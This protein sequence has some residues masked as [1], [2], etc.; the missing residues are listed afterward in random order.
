ML[1]TLIRKELKAIILSPKFTATFAV[2]SVLM[3]ISVY[4][5]I[6]EY[7]AT[8]AQ[9]ASAQQLVDQ[10]MQELTSWADVRDKA[11]RPPDPLQVFVAGLNYDIGRLSNINTHQ[12]VKLQNSI[13]SDDPI[14]A[15]F[16]FIDFAFIVQVVLSLFAILFTYDAVSGEREQGTL[17]LVFSNAIPRAR[18][19][20]AKFAGAWIGLAV[21]ISV[22]ILLGILLV[23]L[24]KVPFTATHWVRLLSLIGVSLLFFTFFIALGV[25]ISTITRRSNVS[26]LIG[27]VVW[28]TF[29]LII[30]RAGVLAAGQLVSV[31][32]VAEIESQRDRYA[33]GLW[34]EHEQKIQEKWKARTN[35]GT[36]ENSEQDE[37]EMWNWLQEDDAL[38]RESQQ[39]I[40]DFSTRLNED[41]R[42]RKAVQTRLAFTLSRI[43]PASAYQLA[44]M[45]IA[46]TDLAMK[47]RYEDVMNEYRARFKDYVEQ[48]QAEDPMGGKMMIS[49][50]SEDGISFNSP[51]EAATID[52]SG[53]PRFVAPETTLAGAVAPAILDFG[54]LALYTLAV[55]AGAFA[56]FLRYDVR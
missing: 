35:T 32:S 16:R 46:G 18:Y 17:R 45:S 3:L 8:A 20:L 7:R 21:P 31:P 14:Y 2:C 22:P 6:R 51:R 29:V 54:L 52:V 34:Q 11:L 40:D 5:G 26:F 56:L 24:Y 55:F 33:Q 41:L 4:I 50:S 30:P 36:S 42:R 15:V 43:S 23:T 38:R 13:Y 44:A 9:Y 39:K 49:I 1:G 47:T 48:K 28:I 25:L 53:L 19:V 10:Q 37:N 12:G 27:L